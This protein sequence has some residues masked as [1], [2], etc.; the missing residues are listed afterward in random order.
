MLRNCLLIGVPLALVAL[1]L[2]AARGQLR[3]LRLPPSAQ[4]VLLLTLA[5]VQEELELDADQIDALDKLAS[6]MHADAMEI[7]SGLQDLTP[8]EQKEAM[9]ELLKMIADKGQKLQARV[10]DILRPKQAARLNELSL[11]RRG[12]AALGD[13]QVAD[14]LKITD[15]QQRSLAAIRQESGVKQR[16]IDRQLSAGVER[17]KIRAT[18]NALRKEF[19]AKILT[20]LSD[21]QRKQFEQMQGAKFKFP[22]NSGQ[23]R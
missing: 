2:S 20:V 5:P 9:P 14:A 12:V 17:A 21:D 3:N 6:Q 10:D 7:L 23:L 4:N 15:E 19:Q 16:E 13:Q 11:Q 8:A 22:P 1:P 18:V